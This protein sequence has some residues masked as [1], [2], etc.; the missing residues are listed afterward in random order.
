MGL[1]RIAREDKS[2]S[3]RLLDLITP[4]VGGFIT[5]AAASSKPARDLVWGWFDILKGLQRKD[6]PRA[7]MRLFVELHELFREELSRV[8]DPWFLWL[9]YFAA[10]RAA[11]FAPRN[12][13]AMTQLSATL[14]FLSGNREQQ[15]AALMLFAE[16][17]SRR[18]D[19]RTKLL[20]PFVANWIDPAWIRSAI[21]AAHKI[22]RA[23]HHY[24]S[25]EDN[26][27]FWAFLHSAK[28]EGSPPQLAIDLR[29]LRKR[30][31][32]A[33]AMG[34][35]DE[36]EEAGAEDLRRLSTELQPIYRGRARS[37][38]R[39]GAVVFCGRNASLEK[40]GACRASRA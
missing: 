36:Q 15:A 9:R 27:P 8:D 17:L 23:E 11:E 13:V 12:S 30:A 39:Q 32:A 10:N 25:L 33:L 19:A 28:V 22:G 20:A 38:T 5:E 18:S 21:E 37:R 35:A 26:F 1:A 4:E 29:E 7:G 3:L 34:F 24:V 14:R 6:M 40:G 16:A 2:A 31:G